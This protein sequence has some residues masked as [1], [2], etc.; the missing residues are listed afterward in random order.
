MNGCC[1]E[2]IEPS[3]KLGRMITFLKYIIVVYFFLIIMD[4]LLI[5]S[6]FFYYLFIQVL[7]LFICISTKHFGHFLFFILLLFFNLLIVFSVLGEWFQYGFYS[8][9]SSIAFCYLV[10]IVIFE[11]FCIFVIFQ[12][13]KQS[14]QEYRIKYGYAEGE[15]EGG[16]NIQNAQ[17]IHDNI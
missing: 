3:V 1:Q 16:E 6:G 7:V 12:C 9:D 17:D 2:V 15:N 11:I 10:F 5:D 4:L 13:Y 14:K 8:N